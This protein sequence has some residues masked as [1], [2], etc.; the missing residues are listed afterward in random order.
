MIFRRLKKTAFTVAYTFSM[1]GAFIGGLV[2][3]AA[4]SLI[5]HS[6]VPENYLVREEILGHLCILASAPSGAAGWH[7]MC[8]DVGYSLADSLRKYEAGKGSAQ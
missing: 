3:P 4:G 6:I 8:R 1:A 5:L 7:Q 2:I